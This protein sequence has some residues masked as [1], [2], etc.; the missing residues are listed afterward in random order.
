MAQYPFNINVGTLDG[1]LEVLR[2]WSDATLEM[3][4]AALI[5]K[6]KPWQLLELAVLHGI[7]P[8]SVEAL[9]QRVKELEARIRPQI[10]KSKRDAADDDFTEIRTSILEALDRVAS[11]ALEAKAY[12]QL[13][14]EEAYAVAHAQLWRTLDL[15]SS[16]RGQFKTARR[17][18]NEALEG[19][20]YTGASLSVLRGLDRVVPRPDYYLI[21]D[22]DHVKPVTEHDVLWCWSQGFLAT[23]TAGEQLG[24]EEG[25]TLS[26]IASQ[27]GVPLPREEALLPAAAATILGDDPVDGDITFHVRRRIRDGRLASY[28]PSD[29]EARRRFEAK[30]RPPDG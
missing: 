9:D 1:Q 25:D 8:P 11:I 24:L 28:F 27:L 23:A 20:E 13:D 3:S 16:T 5:L 2:L 6:V 15:L 10:R 29:V 18:E 30:G 14:A 7:K 19:F 22:F 26:E 12:G 17:I 21:G 4:T